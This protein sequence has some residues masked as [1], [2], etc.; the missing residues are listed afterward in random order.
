MNRTARA[1]AGGGLLRGQ[2]GP[3]RTALTATLA[4]VFA[5]GLL[6]CD[7]N[8]ARPTDGAPTT[9]AS[10]QPTA[11]ASPTPAPVTPSPAPPSVRPTATAEPDGAA[12]P[13]DTRTGIQSVDR[14]LE[15]LYGGGGVEALREV[16]HFRMVE[17]V[18]VVTGAGAPPKCQGSETEG[19]PVEVFAAASCEGFYV[20]PEE[21]EQTLEG[22]VESEPALYAVL[23]WPEENWPP[24]EHVIVA[25]SYSPAAA[26]PLGMQLVVSEEGLAGFLQGCGQ[27]ADMLVSQAV[28]RGAEPVLPPPDGGNPVANPAY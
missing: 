3:A 25:S 26:R 20:R 24:G 7:D 2:R 10:P 19:T 13:P 11:A 5:A 9:T 21:I 16:V 27:P 12:H 6:A 8:D 28:G 4:L 14:V 22:L 15:A 17:C 1:C 18:E 23:T